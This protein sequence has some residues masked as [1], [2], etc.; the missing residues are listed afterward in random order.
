M[1]V[2]TT[3]LA[4]FLLAA[5]LAGS[6]WALWHYGSQAGTAAERKEW[7][8][9]WANRN[10]ADKAAQLSQEKEQRDEERR[11]QTRTEE[12]INEAEREKQRALAAAASA[13]VVADQLQQRLAAIRRQLADSETGRISADAARRQT[14]AETGILLTELYGKLDRRAKEIAEYADAAASAGSRCESIYSAVTNTGNES[15][16]AR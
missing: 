12:I 5:S 8:L 10:E 7:Q 16:V 9:R 1:K 11:R 15:K 14:A 4:G 3:A 6:G 13:G 2:A